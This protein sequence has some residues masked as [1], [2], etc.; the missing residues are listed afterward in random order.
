MQIYRRRR[1]V[2]ALALAF[3]SGATAIGLAVLGFILWTLFANGFEAIGIK[4]FTETTPP[5]GSD[6]GLANAIF[7]SL[8]LTIIGTL[9]SSEPT[10]QEKFNELLV[11]SN[12]GLGAEKATAH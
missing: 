5:P 3:A 11:R 2:N 8:L 9:L 12:T 4:L 1:L 6:G 10:S 7:G